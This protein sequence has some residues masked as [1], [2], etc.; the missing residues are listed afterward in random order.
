M[1]VADADAPAATTDSASRC[2]RIRELKPSEGR[3]Q[4]KHRVQTD[5]IVSVMA[6]LHLFDGPLVQVELGAGKGGLALAASQA[7]SNRSSA[8]PATLVPATTILVDR[9]KPKGSADKALLEAGGRCERIKIDLAHLRLRGVS[10]LWP[11]AEPEGL[12]RAAIGK[13]LC[14]AATD[15]ALRS[16]VG[17]AKPPPGAAVDGVVIATCCHHKCDWRSYVNKA[18]MSAAG[19]SESDFDRLRCLSSWATDAE[20]KN[21]EEEAEDAQ[22][23]IG[24]SQ[25]YES[26]ASESQAEYETSTLLTNHAEAASRLAPAERLRVGWQV[27]RLLDTGRLLYLETHGYRGAMQRYVPASV[28]PENVLL[29]ATPQAQ[30]SSGDESTRDGPSM[31]CVE[32]E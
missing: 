20:H 7:H 5:A 1:A 25:A 18:F 15:F 14:G 13:H 30:R 31:A 29:I 9:I 12:R 4:L 2:P 6:E 26:Q 8:A 11:S 16:L 24:E 17:A 22:D 32:C 10:S 27:K 19:F 21:P 28:S 23:A 3:K